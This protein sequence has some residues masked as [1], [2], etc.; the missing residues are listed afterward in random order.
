M[1][2]VSR[3]VERILFHF[4]MEWFHGG[5]LNNTEG[6]WQRMVKFLDSE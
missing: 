2:W 4:E 1:I 3:W 6:D 5:R